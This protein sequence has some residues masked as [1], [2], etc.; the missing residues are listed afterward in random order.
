MEMDDFY[1]TAALIRKPVYEVRYLMEQF[2]QATV[3]YTR[4]TAS[5]KNMITSHGNDGRYSD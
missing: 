4:S 2:I 3:K 5:K 1:P